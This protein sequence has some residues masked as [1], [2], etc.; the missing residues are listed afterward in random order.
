MIFQNLE[1]FNVSEVSDLGGEYLLSRLPLSVRDRL[2]GEQGRNMAV[3]GTGMELRFVMPGDEV[4]ITLRTV[5]GAG[6]VIAYFGDFQSDWPYG[7][8]SI[9]EAP[10]VITFRK[11]DRLSR[12]T[13][14]YEA[15]G[16]RYSPSVVRL[17]LPSGQVRFISA[18]G[19]MRP[20]ERSLCTPK[21]LLAY[22]SSITHGSL[23]IGIQDSYP[24]LCGAKL[25]YDVMNL[26]L[27]G[28]CRM[29]P[30]VVD[31]IADRGDWDVL[32][33]ELG[34]N[35][36]GMDDSEFSSRA[37]YFVS[38]I[39]R[40]NPDKP[41]FV[42]DIFCHGDDLFGNAAKTDRF[43]EIVKEAVERVDSD[44]VF[45]IRGTELLGGAFDEDGGRPLLGSGFVHPSCDGQRVIGERFAAIIRKKLKL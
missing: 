14:L 26:A 5:S 39:H 1:L 29:E 13:E 12:M 15:R 22:G 7:S 34:I 36:L 31:H 35:V 45:Y 3:S 32:T 20:P 44:K 38:E 19:D 41:M 10:T 30:A 23:A 27:A 11:S 9:N 25:G 42:T 33:A 24:A 2:D 21:K 43:R 6:T 8:F 16:G 40:R 28:A 18:E 4:R 17:L 37:G